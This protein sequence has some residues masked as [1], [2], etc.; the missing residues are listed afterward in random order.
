MTDAR[1]CI[2]GAK[3][4]LRQDRCSPDRQ[5]ESKE[6]ARTDDFESGLVKDLDERWQIVTAVVFQEGVVRRKQG[7]KSRGRAKK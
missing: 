2:C 6:I 7:Q 4:V 1:I 5:Q 3:E